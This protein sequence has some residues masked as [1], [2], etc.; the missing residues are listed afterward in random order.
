M[1]TLTVLVGGSP[2]D[3]IDSSLQI[4]SRVDDKDKCTFTLKDDSGTLAFQKG[5][6]VKVS[7]SALGTLFSGYINKPTCTNLFPNPTNLWSV[8]CVNHF[9]VAAK[10]A[11]SQP[12]TGRRRRGG[13][14]TRQHSGTIAALQIKEYL[15]PSGVSGNFGLDW[16]ELQTDWQ[17][18]TLSG[19]TAATNLTTGNLGAGNLELAPAGNAVVFTESTTAIFA[20]GTL[21]GV[22]A[23]NNTLIPSSLS[24]IKLQ[25]TLNSQ[26]SD[27]DLYIEFWG[28]AYAIQSSDTVTY[29]VWVSSTSPSEQAGLDFV[30]TDG[31][32]FRDSGLLDQ[33]G[34]SCHPKTDISGFA[35]NKW[36][37]RTINMSGSGLVGKTIKYATVVFENNKNAGT[38]TA[39]FRNIVI[40][41]IT[42]F[43][44]NATTTNVSPPTIT[45]N[46][47]FSSIACAI[48]PTYDTAAAYRVSPAYAINISALQLSNI[49]W[50]S[51]T[52]TGTNV[53]IAYSIDN[54]NTYLQCT[55]GAALP[56]LLVGQPLN[57]VSL[58]LKETF[59]NTGADPSISALLSNVQVTL[60]PAY[61]VSLP[62]PVTYAVT[63]QATW[64]AGTLTNTQANSGGDLSTIGFTR[65][66]ADGSIANQTLYGS[67]NQAQALSGQQFALTNGFSGTGGE[68]RSRLDFMG[69]WQNFIFEFDVYV[70]STNVKYGCVYRTTGWQNNDSSWAY[71]VEISTTTVELRKGGNTSSG[72]PSSSSVQLV[73]FTQT[74]T[75]NA[76]YRFKVIVSG[77]NHQIS[78]DNVLYI[79]AT[80]ATW[81]TAGYLGLR[82]RNSTANQ[83]TAKFSDVG[84]AQSLAGTW[85]SSSRSISSVG[86]YGNSIITWDESLTINAA[87]VANTVQISA[88]GGTTYQTCTNGG[89]LPGL[90]PG[91]SL[92]GISLLT[93]VNLTSSTAIAVPD[94]RQLNWSVVPQYLATGLRT[95]APLA[96]DTAYRLNVGSG[97]GTSATGMTYAQVGTATTNLTG[98][99]LQI[100][101]T[102]GDV[103]MV[104]GS[105]TGGDMDGTVRF[106]LSASTISAGLELRYVS[107]GTF[108]RFSANTTTLTLL[109]KSASISITLATASLALLTNTFYRLRFRVTGNLPVS[110]SARVW[111]DGSTEPSTW[112]I[113]GSD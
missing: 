29:D 93:K 42:I 104:A 51:T 49:Q 76:W 54:G 48:T 68:S 26:V 67:S 3:V 69:Q 66:F 21:T 39:F 79:N 71:A 4:T 85:L 113:S 25:G 60:T 50:T 61:A 109:K 84:I 110:L 96:A 9:Y 83:Y 89:A 55:N 105:A 47:G 19:A 43:A 56:S 16:T 13:K 10:K 15:E 40:G 46:T 74:L 27:G 90:T 33:N 64:L 8:D 5:Q 17:A 6:T 59:A 53:S 35:S 101:N 23:T 94:I 73:T 91:Q 95:N 98:N 97:F 62:S 37:S 31:T 112:N 7:D 36:Y 100:V 78:I 63:T 45:K 87:S 41:G 44:T 65:F 72:S 86:T 34:I 20:A 99:E 57:S 30:C 58:L 102:T 12:H 80:D 82:N 38:Y 28:G 2:V 108:Y 106:S 88:D 52:P 11:T 92:S 1:S 77:N 70:D 32:T 111:L 24:A 75:L 22:Q 107:A 18:G 103:H 14:H 81:T